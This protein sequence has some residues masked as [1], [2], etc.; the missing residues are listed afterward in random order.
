MPTKAPQK[1]KK[2]Q[3][4]SKP[5]PQEPKGQHKN[6]PRAH[7]HLDTKPDR[8]RMGEGNIPQGGERPAEGEYGNKERRQRQG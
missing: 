5:G 8:K 1:P 6:T 7:E 4:E 2:A 3:Q